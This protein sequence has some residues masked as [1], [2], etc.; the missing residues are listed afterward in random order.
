MHW[1]S[2]QGYLYGG[3]V[4]KSSDI[5]CDSCRR[6]RATK[7]PAETIQSSQR[8]LAKKIAYNS[9]ESGDLR[10]GD[11][12]SMDQYSSTARGRL[13]KGYGTAPVNETYGGGTIFVVHASGFM[14][15]EHQGYIIMYPCGTPGKPL[16]VDTTDC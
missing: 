1:L 8:V 2:K 3:T 15:V 12:V 6:A 10:L 13:T 7:Q 9:I 14:H 11:R 16:C 4:D 5:V